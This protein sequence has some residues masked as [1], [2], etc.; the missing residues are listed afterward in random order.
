MPRHPEPTALIVAKGKTHISPKEAEERQS[1]EL[2]VPFTDVQ[3][4]EYLSAK[5]K[6]KFDDIAEKLLALEIMTELD[7]D[8]LARY[9]L[10]RYVLAHDVYLAYTSQ[11]TK[12]IKAGDIKAIKEMQNL[13][14]K[15]FRQAQSAAR[16]LGLTITSRCRIVV[17]HPAEE[18]DEL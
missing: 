8:C 10:A 12:Y 18:D 13:Q 5:Q 9:V 15:A 6:A 7:V 14:D 2:K 17:P 16:D 1:R 4:P 11:V 3:A